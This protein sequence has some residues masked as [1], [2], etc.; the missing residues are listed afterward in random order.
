MHNKDVNKGFPGLFYNHK[1]Q[2]VVLLVAVN[3]IY[4]RVQNN[5][6]RIEHLTGS[7]HLE[8]LDT[9]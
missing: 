5:I 9:K 1:R 6:H 7:P 2:L 3:F 4:D 8:L